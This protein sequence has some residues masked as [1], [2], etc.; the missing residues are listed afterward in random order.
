MAIPRPTAF[1]KRTPSGRTVVRRFR[2]GRRALLAGGKDR[3]KEWDVVCVEECR[4]GKF[5]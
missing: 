4:G 2:A 5:A 3:L 1:S